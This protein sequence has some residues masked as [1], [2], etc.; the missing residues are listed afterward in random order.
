MGPTTTGTF[1]P[2]GDHTGS[3]IHVVIEASEP[4][5]IW[6]DDITL[7]MDAP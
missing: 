4:V 1:E 7:T 5:E 6:I 3:W 2:L